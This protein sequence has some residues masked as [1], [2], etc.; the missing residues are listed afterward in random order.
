MII[1]LLYRVFV[2]PTDVL[3]HYFEI[4][5]YKHFF[6]FGRSSQLFSWLY[7]DGTFPLANYVARIWWQA[8]KTTGLANANFIGNFWADFGYIGVIISCF[9]VGIVIHLLYWKLLTV[10]EYSKNVIY[11]TCIAVMVPIFTFVFFSSNFTT[12]F[13]TRG[14]ILLILLLFVLEHIKNRVAN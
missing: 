8:P 7:E 4:F 5:P 13:F 1:T 3:Y 11:T 12:L 6:L 2:V 9:V 10:T 14:L